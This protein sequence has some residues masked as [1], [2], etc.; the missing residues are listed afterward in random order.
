MSKLES[1]LIKREAAPKSR[2]ICQEVERKEKKER[3]KEGK[4]ETIQ[5]PHNGNLGSP[6]RTR[7]PR[8]SAADLIPRDLYLSCPIADFELSSRTS[9]RGLSPLRPTEVRVTATQVRSPLRVLRFV[10]PSST[11][12]LPLCLSFSLTHSFLL[13]FFFFNIFSSHSPSSSSYSSLSLSPSLLFF[14]RQF[15][16]AV[17]WSGRKLAL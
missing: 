12:S 9:Q 3:V 5:K 6:R 17:Q 10:P 8:R 7:S 4:K 16:L 15:D 2:A 13:P 1:R 11:F 14:D